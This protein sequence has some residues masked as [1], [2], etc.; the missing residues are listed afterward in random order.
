MDIVAVTLDISLQRARNRPR[1]RP[2]RRPPV[3][4]EV[5]RPSG[6]S[7]VMAMAKNYQLPEFDDS[8]SVQT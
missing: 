8:D 5:E 2:A 3:A 6:K 4:H 7:T 1:A